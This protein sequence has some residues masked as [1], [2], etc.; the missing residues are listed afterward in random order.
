MVVVKI[1]G[2]VTNDAHLL[3]ELGHQPP[4]KKMKKAK[5]DTTGALAGPSTGHGQKETLLEEFCNS[6]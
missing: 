2:V 6:V 5:E 3:P 1:V 4:K